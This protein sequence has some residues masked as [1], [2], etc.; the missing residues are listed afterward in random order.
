[1]GAWNRSK[2]LWGY[3]AR[4]SKLRALPVEYIVETTAKCNLYCPMCPRETHKQPKAD[5]DGEV[6]RKLVSQSKGSAEHMM[7]IGLGEPF[8]D[9]A[10]FDRIEFCHEHSVSSLLST[11]GTFLDE[12][13]AARILD[14]PL[15]Q[16]TLS[17]DGAKKETFEFYRK[18][19]K[20]EKVRD[21]FVR[22]ARMKHER[23]SKLQVVVQMVKMEGNADEVPDF[24][25]FWNAVP[26]IDQIRI[27]E[28]E[29]NLMR[30][31]AGHAAGEW[32]HPCHYLW[33][34]PMYVKQNG[35]VYP[36]CQSYMLDGAPVGN[37]ADAPLE[38]I[39]NSGGM[40]KLRV[41]HSTGR[42]GEIDMCA[43]CC[44]TIPHPVLVTG[45]LMLHGK[46]VRRLLPVVERLAY[47]S[48][49]PGKLLRPPARN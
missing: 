21:N 25:A 31:D 28:D 37:I 48:K 23:H 24:L 11:N 34:G 4:R 15:E 9:P 27:K 36:C 20:F 44:T 22:F 16:I 2:L 26:G 45:S 49:L 5:M 30:P 18:G 43:R 39:W 12:K 41:L 40:Q 32:S 17:F 13:L 42:A 10:I 3:L 33:R 19:A 47:L 35:D 46:T 1:M 14:S 7:L 29:T 38:E 8:M 6:F